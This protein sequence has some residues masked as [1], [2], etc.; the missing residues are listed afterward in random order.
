MAEDPPDGT[1]NGRDRIRVALVED[2]RLTREGLGALLDS[3]AELTCVGLYAS[4]E[5]AAAGLG[6]APCDVLLLD[7]HLP[8]M[9]GVEGVRVLTEQFPEMR[10]LMLTVYEDE[11][12]VFESIC[13]G[14]SGYLLKKTP[15]AQLVEAVRQARLGGTPLSPEI[16]GHIVRRFRLSPGAARPKPLLTAQEIRLLHLLAD[17]HSYQSASGRLGVTI[18]TVRDHVR[19]VYEKL[20]VHSRSEA[21]SKGLRRR[22]IE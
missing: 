13:N 19:A 9:S 10:V 8:G 18:N 5:R 14:A 12:R 15:P 1:M 11:E 3:S 2:K 7:I 20:H 16:A 17:G 6:A 21:V 22:L 4:V